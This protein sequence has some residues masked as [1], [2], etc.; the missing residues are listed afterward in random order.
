MG[1][2]AL[3]PTG[4]TEGDLHELASFLH[5]GMPSSPGPLVL[6]FLIAVHRG[7]TDVQT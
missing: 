2:N 7:R 4:Y 1:G 3:G 6:G 5:F